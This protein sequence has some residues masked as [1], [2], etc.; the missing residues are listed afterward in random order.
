MLKIKTEIKSSSIH[1]LGLFA[2]EDIAKG[3]VVHEESPGLDLV[4]EVEKFSVLS[5]DEQAFIEYYGWLDKDDDKYHLNF[6]HSRFI[7][8]SS[9]S[10][11]LTFD[12]THNAVVAKRAIKIGEELTED[13]AEFEETNLS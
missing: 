12:A 10:A 1:G 3:Q 7:N 4:I 13:Y 5:P 9:D 11:N 2:L 6:D 8:H